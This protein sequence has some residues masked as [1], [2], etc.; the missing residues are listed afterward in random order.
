MLRVPILGIVHR[1]ITS[2]QIV[3]LRGNDVPDQDA[4]GSISA[5]RLDG[6]S[7]LQSLGR[8]TGARD[9]GTEDTQA[10]LATLVQAVDKLHVTI[11]V[12]M[13]K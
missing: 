8:G 13:G 11:S 4:D 2:S 7:G 10:E 6:M 5:A 3:R 12:R 9:H 1:S